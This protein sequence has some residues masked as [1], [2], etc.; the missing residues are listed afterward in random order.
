M[1]LGERGRADPRFVSWARK[2]G[3]V[4]RRPRSATLWRIKEGIDTKP[5]QAQAVG[6][7]GTAGGRAEGR[8]FGV[9]E[10]VRGP[11]ARKIPRFAKIPRGKWPSERTPRL[12][13]S[14]L[15]WLR[16]YLKSNEERGYTTI[17]VL[18]LQRVR[19]FQFPT[20]A[21]VAVA[22]MEL[23]SGRDRHSQAGEQLAELENT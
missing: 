12:V 16:S 15:P 13:P 19:C 14:S 7:V 4:G 10:G 3:V 17:R 9:T 1:T 5:A 22:R 2:G 11:F 23:L 8:T 21:V 20:S 18:Y 6:P